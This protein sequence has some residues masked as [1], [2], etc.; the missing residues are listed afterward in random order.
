MY[1]SR[2]QLVAFPTSLRWQMILPMVVN[3]ASTK[4]W[5]M[6]VFQ[7]LLVSERTEA[8]TQHVGS[9]LQLGLLLPTLGSIIHYKPTM[10]NP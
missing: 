6:H 4:Y 7:V 3:I 2:I 9:Q 5:A 8:A 10:L 1:L